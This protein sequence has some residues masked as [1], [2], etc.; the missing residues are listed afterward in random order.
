MAARG[1]ITVDGIIV[2]DGGAGGPSFGLRVGG[3]VIIK[4]LWSRVPGLEFRVQGLGW[5]ALVTGD[6]FLCLPPR[7]LMA[8]DVPVAS[9]GAG[10]RV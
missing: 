7:A 5:E 1:V 10:C 8:R 4:G 6:Q 2:V 9:D 3:Q